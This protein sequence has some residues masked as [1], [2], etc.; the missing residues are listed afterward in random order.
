VSKDADA[1]ADAADPGA[2]VTI[3]AARGQS[4]ATFSLQ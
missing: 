2:C 1:A 4:T 3:V